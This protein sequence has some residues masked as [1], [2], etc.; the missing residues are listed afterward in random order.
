MIE[1][2][3]IL[4]SAVLMPTNARVASESTAER[5]LT[6]AE[7]LFLQDGYEAVSVRAINTAAGLSP[8]A[9]HYHFGSKDG[10]VA[11]LL[12]ERLAPLWRE[13][14][15]EIA[16]RGAA[17][18]PAGVAELVDAILLPLAELAAD[19]VG[20]LRLHLL[21]RTVLAG[22]PPRWSSHW[23]SLAPWVERLR[24]AHP[25]L[26]PEE[27]AYRWQLA[28]DLILLQFGDPLAE[29]Q[30]SPPTP[31]VPLPTLAAFVAAG[32]T[33]PVGETSDNPERR[34]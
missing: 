19:P 18:R 6:V 4:C 15:D 21:A 34:Q 31:S 25:E 26:T 22:K 23:F 10:L 16:E 3:R 30:G 12:E 24:A 13:R 17:G 2:G 11:R 7:S 9:V 29:R 1:S 14:L 32:L 27:A 8:A 28:F 33:A 20:R 5:L